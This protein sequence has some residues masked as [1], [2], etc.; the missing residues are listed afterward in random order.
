MQHLTALKGLTRPSVSRPRP[1]PK[2]GSHKTK[3]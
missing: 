1:R 2:V 3:R